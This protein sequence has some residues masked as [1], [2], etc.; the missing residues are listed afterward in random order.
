VVEVSI[1]QQACK[2]DATEYQ[3]SP[4]KTISSGGDL[5]MGFNQQ[6][7][8]GNQKSGNTVAVEMFKNNQKSGDTVA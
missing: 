5:G 4:T 8:K 1:F 7:F 2:K 6:A 3:E